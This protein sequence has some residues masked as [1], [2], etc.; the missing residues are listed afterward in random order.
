MNPL[1]DMGQLVATPGIVA[2]MPEYAPEIAFYLS[3]H[4]MGE[5]GDGDKQANNY[6]V[7]HG[8]RLLSAYKLSDTIR[9]RIITEWDRSVTT[10]LLPEEY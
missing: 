3:Q 2:L 4:L 8:E 6:A 1:F 10:I 7:E 9:I 5:W